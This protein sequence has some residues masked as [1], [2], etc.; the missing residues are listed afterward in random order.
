ML[1]RLKCWFKGHI[2]DQGSTWSRTPWINHNQQ[3][4]TR[5]HIK[6]KRCGFMADY[7]SPRARLI[8]TE[9]K[10]GFTGE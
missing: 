1:N 8:G 2:R 10:L 9:I 7:I 4:K 3:G 5:W 6:C